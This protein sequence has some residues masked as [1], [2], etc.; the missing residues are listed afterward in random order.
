MA[1][2]RVAS[3]SVLLLN[4]I[5][6]CGRANSLPPDYDG[7]DI[8]RILEGPPL[9]QIGDP[10]YYVDAGTYL[11]NMAKQGKRIDGWC[12]SAK[13]EMDVIRYCILLLHLPR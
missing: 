11:E 8:D 3:F 10:N 5:L 12:S 13:H 9:D 4:L 6:I 1:N 2:A 7:P